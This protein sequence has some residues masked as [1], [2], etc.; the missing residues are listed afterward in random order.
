MICTCYSPNNAPPKE[1]AE[2]VTDRESYRKL[3]DEINGK[4][5]PWAFN[6]WVWALTF[7]SV[8]IYK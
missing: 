3:W 2:G 8:G 7:K 5:Y 4:K 6:H 1:E